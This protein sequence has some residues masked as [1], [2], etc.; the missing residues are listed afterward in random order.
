MTIIKDVERRSGA[1][2]ALIEP[3]DKGVSDEVHY[4]FIGRIP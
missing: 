2:L 1:V 4:A 3:N